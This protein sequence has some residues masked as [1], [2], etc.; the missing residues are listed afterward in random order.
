MSSSPVRPAVEKPF[1]TFNRVQLEQQIQKGLRKKMGFSRDPKP[2][3]IP[4]VPP[5]YIFNV[6]DKV[7]NWTQPGFGFFTIPACG[8]DEDCSGPIYEVGHQDEPGIKG[9]VNYEFLEIDKT[10][11]AQHLGQEI[12][13]E[14]LGIGAGKT[15]EHNLENFGLFRSWSNPPKQSEIKAAKERFIATLEHIVK[16]GNA[17]YAQGEKRGPDGN[18]LSSE[19][20]WAANLLGQQEPWSRTARQMIA[21]PECQFD[22]PANASVHFGPGGCGAVIDPDRAF[23]AGLID[24]KKYDQ[25]MSARKKRAKSDDTIQ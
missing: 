9:V 2:L 21:C 25:V 24:Q 5:I 17:I 23:D 8:K 4:G 16:D 15:P 6:S 11:W 7:Y 14:I 22:M 12:A 10:K 13:M 3:E 1:N 19:H 18:M 20:K